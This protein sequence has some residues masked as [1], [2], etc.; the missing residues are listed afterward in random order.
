MANQTILL[1]VFPRTV[2][3][4]TNTLPVSVFV[5]P[6]LTGARTLGAFPD[7]MNWTQLLKDNGFQISV[8]VNGHSI[9]AAIDTRPLRP[10]LWAALFSAETLVDNYEFSDYSDRTV[11]SYA[12]RDAM[13]AVQ[14]VYQQAAKELGLPADPRDKESGPRRAGKLTSLLGGF[15]LDEWSDLHRRRFRSVFGQRLDRERPARRARPAASVGADGLLSAAHFIE[16]P[17]DMQ[18]L[19]EQVGSEFALYSRMPPGVPDR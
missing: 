6:Q 14:A 17:E 3:V 1:T 12:V 16:E 4:V 8:D 13:L 9:D 2:S 5:S 19:K 18:L 10:D 15:Q 7:W 11:I